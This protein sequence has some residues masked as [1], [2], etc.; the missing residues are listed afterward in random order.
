MHLNNCWRCGIMRM[1]QRTLWVTFFVILS[2]RYLLIWQ[3]GH[4]IA[5]SC[6]LWYRM[7]SLG[8]A[9]IVWYFIPIWFIMLDNSRYEQ[10]QMFDG[11][12]KNSLINLQQQICIVN[13]MN[14]NCMLTLKM[15]KMILYITICEIATLDIPFITLKFTSN[16]IVKRSIV[17]EP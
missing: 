7:W 14:I 3:S 17:L 4:S 12:K 11:S 8:Y 5:N 2:Y 15:T 13:I 6:C 10:G 16:N 9:C 1:Y